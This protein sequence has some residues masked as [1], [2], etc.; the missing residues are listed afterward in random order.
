MVEAGLTRQEA[1]KRFVICTSVGAIGK[2]DGTHGD[3]NSSRGLSEE[4]AEW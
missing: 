3:P 4:R 2:A 1:M